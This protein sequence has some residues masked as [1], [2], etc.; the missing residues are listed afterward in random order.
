M[1][2]FHEIFAKLEWEFSLSVISREHTVEKW[3]IYVLSQKNIS[4]N[5]IKLTYI[6]KIVTFT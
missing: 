3:K 1:R 5:Q 2:W 4:S 6:S